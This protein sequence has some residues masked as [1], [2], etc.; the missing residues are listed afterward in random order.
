MCTPLL[1]RTRNRPR[2]PDRR[3][4]SSVHTPVQ[5]IT[6]SAWTSVSPPSSTS[7]TRTP[8]TRSASREEPDDL[9][10]RPHHRAVVR[11]RARHGHACAGRR[12]T[13]RR[14]S[15]S[16]RSARDRLSAGTIRS[17][18]A[19]V[20]C[21]WPGHRLRAPPIVSYISRPAAVYGP[22]PDAVRERVEEADRLDQV[23]R[24]PASASAHARAAPPGPGRTRAAP[25]SAGR[26]GTACWTGSTCPTRGRGPRRA[27][28]AGRAS[29]RPAPCRTPTTPPPMTT[30]S[31][32]SLT[33][34]L[35]GSARSAVPSASRAGSSPRACC[36]ARTRLARAGDGCLPRPD[37]VIQRRPRYPDLDDFGWC[38]P[39]RYSDH[40]SRLRRCRG[41]LPRPRYRPSSLG[42]A[43]P[44]VPTRPKWSLTPCLR[45]V[46][47]GG[48]RHELWSDHRLGDCWARR[49]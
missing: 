12:R 22:L 46:R 40:A 6:A 31:K 34:P 49:R 11:G 43:P 8:D 32:V 18:P 37:R 26:R 9:G 5:L 29:P 7:R 2:P 33:Q 1:A 14:S 10:R 41:Q 27:R 17:A 24:E 48:G 47:R 45:R 13:A 30:T 21:F 44:P 35:P 28:P 20:R 23:R 39:P 42:S 25:G 16:R 15:G 4:S 19:R 38:S 36:A 3:C